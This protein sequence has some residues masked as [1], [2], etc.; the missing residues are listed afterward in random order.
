MIMLDFM[1]SSV[2]IIS[3]LEPGTKE[4]IVTCVNI[5]VNTSTLVTSDRFLQTMAL[6]LQWICLYKLLFIFSFLAFYCFYLCLF[7]FKQDHA[8]K[9]HFCFTSLMFC[10]MTIKRNLES[11][12]GFTMKTTTSI[13]TPTVT[14]WANRHVFIVWLLLLVDNY[15]Y[16]STSS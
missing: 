4:R 11:G 2:T 13:V 15:S 12:G 5:S 1:W 3:R 10:K 6:H 8:T 9:F 14:T 7:C 16:A